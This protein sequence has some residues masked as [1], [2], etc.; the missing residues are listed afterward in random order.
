MGT[1][2]ASA[3]WRIG[4]GPAACMQSMG[5]DWGPNG[6]YRHLETATRLTRAG[7]SAIQLQHSGVPTAKT[8]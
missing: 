2:H 3:E 4:P 5:T 1:L 8:H 7:C 6:S